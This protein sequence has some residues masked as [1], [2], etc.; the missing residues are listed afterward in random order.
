[1]IEINGMV[2]FKDSPSFLPKILFIEHSMTFESERLMIIQ[3][4]LIYD[5]SE[6]SRFQAEKK[7]MTR[8]SCKWALFHDEDSSPHRSGFTEVTT[9]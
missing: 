8:F 7:I 1:M 2:I 4:G 3:T 9:F 5:E 6:D